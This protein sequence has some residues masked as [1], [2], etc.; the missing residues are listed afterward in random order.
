[1][2][3]HTL[4]LLLD[5]ARQTVESHPQAGYGAD[6]PLYEHLRFAVLRDATSARTRRLLVRKRPTVSSK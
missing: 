6:Q 1:M 2:T 5:E 3:D 4:E